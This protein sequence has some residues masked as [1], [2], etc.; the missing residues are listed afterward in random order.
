[1]RNTSQSSKSGVIWQKKVNDIYEWLYSHRVTALDRLWNRTRLKPTFSD[2]TNMCFKSLQ[3]EHIC[4]GISYQGRLQKRG[5]NWLSPCVKSWTSW[6]DVGKVLQKRYSTHSAC[7]HTPPHPL[8]LI[9]LH[10]K[11]KFTSFRQRENSS[12]HVHPSYK[13]KEESQEGDWVFK[14]MHL[15][16]FLLSFQSSIFLSSKT[17]YW[18]SRY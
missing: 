1:M 12:W 15:F 7:A 8:F 2:V 18:G 6:E 16:F 10:P 17:A 3:K 9:M 5:K 11:S 14:S 4:E 13:V